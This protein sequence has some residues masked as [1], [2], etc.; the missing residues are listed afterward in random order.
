MGIIAFVIVLARTNL[1]ELWHWFREV[2][3]WMLLAAL[4][5]QVVMLSVKS[6]RWLLL[7]E[8]EVNTSR[9]LQRF[10]EFL[11]AYALGAVT[12][13]RMGE[14][15]KAGHAKG[16]SGVVSSGLIVV[17]ER[18]FDLSI[19]FLVAGMSIV[20]GYLD[21]L[22]HFIGY[23]LVLVAFAGMIVAVSILVIPAITHWVIGIMKKIRIVPADAIS[24]FA[25]RNAKATFSFFALSVISNL[26][27]FLSFYY[28]AGAV[29]LTPGFMIIS[30]SVALAGVIN[31]I[32]VTVMGIGTRDITLLYTLS[33][34]PRAQVI[35]FSSMILLV[36]QIFGGVLAL[37]G[38]QVFLWKAKRDR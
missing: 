17:A 14:L 11:E 29:H 16:K 33:G 4:L 10:G 38:G 8:S 2:D 7:N 31:T 35:A 26:C 24:H 19:F 25:R 20:L 13:G 32:P 1:N 9:V 37:I 22:D 3:L 12:P 15:L 18:G 21:I 30:G 6:T 34:F 36:F 28:T 27:A 23:I 5:L